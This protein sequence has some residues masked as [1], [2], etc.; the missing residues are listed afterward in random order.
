MPK[1]RRS[2]RMPH[3]TAR[4]KPVFEDVNAAAQF[5]KSLS[6]SHPVALYF[7]SE[8]ERFGSDDYNK[9]RAKGCRIIAVV[10]IERPQ[11]HQNASQVV[12][13]DYSLLVQELLNLRETAAV[14]LRT[15]TNVND[16]Y[17]HQIDTF[18]LGQLLPPDKYMS[19]VNRLL[20]LQKDYTLLMF[21]LRPSHIILSGQNVVF[22]AALYMRFIKCNFS[23]ARIF[24]TA[25]YRA[26]KKHEQTENTTGKAIRTALRTAT[27]NHYGYVRKPHYNW[28]LTWIGGIHYENK[29]YSVIGETLNSRALHI[30][31]SGPFMFT[32]GRRRMCSK[33]TLAQVINL[34]LSWDFWNGLGPMIIVSH[35]QGKHARQL[36]HDIWFAPEFNIVSIE[37]VNLRNVLH[38]IDTFKHTQYDVYSTTC[39]AG[40]QMIFICK[41]GRGQD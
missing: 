40:V 28:H 13:W 22:N 14:F 8:L 38:S 7:S 39:L 15:Q 6:L 33:D 36:K 25:T 26:I 1:R 12:K 21:A 19:D 17:S 5:S 32:L 18:I 34:D 4:G 11:H 23:C 37:R 20:T 27:A 24:N 30:F 10:N 31:H 29:H 35:A 2:L 41:I 3:Q 16:T 9:V